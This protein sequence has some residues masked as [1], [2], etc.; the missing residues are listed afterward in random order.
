MLLMRRELRSH[1]HGIHVADHAVLHSRYRIFLMERE[2]VTVD[3]DIL[4]IGPE[5]RPGGRCQLHIQIEGDALW[6]RGDSHQVLPAGHTQVIHRHQGWRCRQAG[7]QRSL[8]IEWD[9]GL[10]STRHLETAGPSSLSGEARRRIASCFD[11]LTRPGISE[12]EA[13]PATRELLAVLRS[14]GFPFDPIDA[15]TLREAVPPAVAQLSTAIDDLLSSLGDRPA[16]VDLETR[17]GWSRNRIHTVLERFQRTYAF[18]ITGGWRPLYHWWRVP[19]GLA[20]MSTGKLRT[21]DAA[22]M[23]GYASPRALCNAFANAGLPSPGSVREA[24]RRL[25]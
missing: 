24:L 25:S 7:R 2:G 13:A 17:L 18:H 1:R 11:V 3:D 16:I 20:L 23:L 19:L 6:R 12:E 5:T 22:T 21:E 14:E 8:F 15:H 9:P 4:D 10:L